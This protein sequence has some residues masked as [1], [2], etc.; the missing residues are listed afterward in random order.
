MPAP[1]PAADPKGAD[2]TARDA[3]RLLPGIDA[4]P[5]ARAV[6]VPALAPGGSASHAYLFHGPAG[7]GKR[8]VARTFAAALLADGA[9]S[10]DTVAE[11]VARGSHPDLTWVTPSGAAEMLVADIEE[12][13]V[14]AA[15]RTPFESARRVFVIE[16]AE[17]M[18]DQAA[19]RMLKT[20]EEPPAFTHLLLLADRREDVL[21]TIASRCQ[22]VRFDPLPSA[23]I[24]ELLAPADADGAAGADAS[25]REGNDFDERGRVLACSRLALGDA[26]V[27]A[28]LASDEGRELRA[29]AEELVRCA[30]S[31]DTSARPWLGLLAAAKAAGAAAGEQLRERLQGE[32]E[33]LPSK[34]RK[35]HEREGAEAQRRGERRTRTRTLDLGL[36]LAE[37]WLRDLLC[38]REGAPELVYAV[39]R[40]ERLEQDAGGAE[41]LREDAREGRGL[42]PVALRRGVELVADTRLSLSLNVSEELALEALAYRLQALFAGYALVLN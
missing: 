30:L 27:A 16:G 4:H 17:T 12:P 23:L 15:A 22:P 14:A 37:L 18:N 33:L 8:A 10:P 9:R 38:V 1:S 21:A 11:R 29:R 24:A 31:G 40:A 19:N 39:D 28:R 42:D 2:A 20:L 35:R 34:E 5:H 32:L 13:V 41:A 25:T 7:T 3:A 26:G 36:R 6:L